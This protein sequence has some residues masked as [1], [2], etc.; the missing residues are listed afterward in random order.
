MCGWLDAT[1]ACPSLRQGLDGHDVS[2]LAR[3]G[4][5]CSHM[6]SLASLQQRAVGGVHVVFFLCLWCIWL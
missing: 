1:D 3:C 6:C 5:C 2:G 4:L